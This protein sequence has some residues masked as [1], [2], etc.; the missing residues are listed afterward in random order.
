MRNQDK[1]YKIRDI[2]RNKLR[3]G[4][5][6]NLYIWKQSTF[7]DKRSN[8]SKLQILKCRHFLSIRLKK[9]TYTRRLLQEIIVL[10]G[11]LKFFFEITINW[12]YLNMSVKNNRD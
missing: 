2:S 11:S 9:N 6:I 4:H 1:I 12:E 10:F 7:E 5:H 8:L 3:K